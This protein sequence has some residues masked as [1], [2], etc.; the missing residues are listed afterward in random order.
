MPKR[1]VSVIVTQFPHAAVGRRAWRQRE[2]A[3]LVVSP[4]HA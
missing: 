2:A 3:I 1:S 4:R